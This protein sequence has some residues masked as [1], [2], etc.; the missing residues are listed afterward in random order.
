MGL[1]WKT[2]P[3]LVP[4]KNVANRITKDETTIIAVLRIDFGILNLV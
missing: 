1:A 3:V 2:L 4:A